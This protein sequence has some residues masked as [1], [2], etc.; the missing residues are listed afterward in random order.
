[1]DGG[2]LTFIVVALTFL[3]GGYVKGVIGVGL[4]TI[5]MGLLSLTMPPAQAAA[6]L[7]APTLATN[8]WQAAAGSRMAALLRRLWSMFLGI[9]IGT[10]ASAGFLTTGDGDRAITMLGIVLSLYAVFGLTAFRFSVTARAEPWL[11]P[12]VGA[13]TGVASAATGVFMIPSVPYLQ[14]LAFDKDELVQAIG[15]SV[16]VSTVSLAAILVR[17]GA[18]HTSIASASLASVVPSLLGMLLG[19]MTRG[20]LSP[21]IFRLCFFSGLFMLGATLAL[22]TVL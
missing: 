15:L 20:R 18:L 12:L 17:D 10:W 1:M 8:I 16:L 2:V 4:P 9:C 13:M 5:A 21:D 7:I 11:S 14:A 6:L 19:Q 22:R 3:F